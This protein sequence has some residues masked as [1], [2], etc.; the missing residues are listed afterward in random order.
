MKFIL[1][2]YLTFNGSVESF[3][4]KT[5]LTEQE[6]VEQ[7]VTLSKQEWVEVARGL[8]VQGSAIKFQCEPQ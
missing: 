2:A 6:C 1:V 3:E 5:N 4:V 8:E 7:A